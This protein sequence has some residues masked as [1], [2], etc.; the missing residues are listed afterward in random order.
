[1]SE[2]NAAEASAMR[3]TKSGRKKPKL[4]P[5]QRRALKLQG[6]Y[7]GTMRGLKPREQSKVKAMRKSRGINAAITLAGKLAAR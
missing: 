5:A 7:M 1:L 6:R 3:L 2:A 4:S